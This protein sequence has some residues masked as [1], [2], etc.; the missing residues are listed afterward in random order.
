MTRTRAIAP[1]AALLSCLV[2]ASGVVAARMASPTLWLVTPVVAML[3][4]RAAL[5]EGQAAIDSGVDVGQLP[6]ELRVTVVAALTRLPA[7]DARTLL[8]AVVRQGC[9]F[10]ARGESRFSAAEERGVREHV[11]S[12]VEACTS[13]AMDLARLDELSATPRDAGTVKNDVLQR[14]TATRDLFRARLTDAASALTALYASG[15]ER[16][17]PATDRVAEL[18]AAISSDASARAQATTE[19]AA[20]LG[21]G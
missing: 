8:I 11:T 3:I 4:L 12:L 16:G 5:R 2:V 14:L 6:Q 9:L 15:V 18:T 1:S 10:F 17:T 21:E 13:T 19:M 7:G 20:L